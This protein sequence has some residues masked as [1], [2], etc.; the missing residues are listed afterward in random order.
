MNP[1]VPEITDV[2]WA[3]SVTLNTVLAITALFFRL[4][5]SNKRQ[6]LSAVLIILFVP[7]VGSI[8]SLIV[9]KRRRV[10]LARFSRSDTI[11][12]P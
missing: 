6:L 4:R 1:L 7:I 11:T 3:F 9:T 10:A 12:V 8:V 5:D 2:F